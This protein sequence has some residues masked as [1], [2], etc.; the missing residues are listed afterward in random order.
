MG[1]QRVGN[2]I[3]TDF[4]G[5]ETEEV[6]SAST[7]DSPTYQEETTYTPQFSKWKRTD[8]LCRLPRF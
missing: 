5:Q 7:L 8:G 2:G 4:T 6:G 1:L 3:N